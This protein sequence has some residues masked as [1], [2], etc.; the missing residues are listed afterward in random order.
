MKKIILI[1]TTLILIS[2]V[3]FPQI[4]TSNLPSLIKLDVLE[5]KKGLIIK[6]NFRNIE[7]LMNIDYHKL[8]PTMTYYKY[9]VG[10]S[11]DLNKS[12]LYSKSNTED[13]TSIF[14]V[15]NGRKIIFT[16]QPEEHNL[17]EG[18]KKELSNAIDNKLVSF[19]NVSFGIDSNGNPIEEY[20]IKTI[21]KTLYLKFHETTNSKGGKTSTVVIT[22][23]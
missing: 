13:I 11:D 8:E 19:D 16:F 12:Y 7:L 2:F 18:F 3:T 1:T 15:N 4:S 6:P 21:N 17:F 5:S 22:R 14:W 9:E 10:A 20:W 23:K